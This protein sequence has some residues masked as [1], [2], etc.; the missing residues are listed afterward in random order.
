M[1]TQ[2]YNELRKNMVQRQLRARGIRDQRVLEV[3]GEIPR[4]L[5]VPESLRNEAYDD[6]PAPIGEGQTISQ[7]YMVAVMTQLL[8][9]RGSERVLEV[10]TGSGYQTA[11]LSRLCAWVFTVER[12]PAL[13]ARAESLLNRLGYNNI[14]FRV[15]DG[16]R[17]WACEAPF[18]AI[19][20][21]AGAP[22]PPKVLLDQLAQG[23]R[24]VAPVGDRFSQTLKRFVKSD[25]GVTV[26]SHTE[27]R[28]VDLIGE[29]GWSEG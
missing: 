18:D 26:E 28:F 16:T 8:A 2:D 4:H 7:P 6:G 15:G 5:F 1:K 25:A 11:V 14:S 21:T 3:M 29:F 17:G 27:C 19:M 9:L 12:R 13:A 22:A 24:L 10:G 23:G 20:V